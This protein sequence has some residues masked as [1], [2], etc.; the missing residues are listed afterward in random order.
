MS[1]TKNTTVRGVRIKD[2]VIVRL[3]ERATRKK[4]TVNKYINFALETILRP[5]RKKV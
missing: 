3:N 5:H 2:E 1:P 4:W